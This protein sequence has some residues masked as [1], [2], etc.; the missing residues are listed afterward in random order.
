MNF[1]TRRRPRPVL[2]IIS[3]IDLLIVLL[4]FLVVSTSFREATS[5]LQLSL[6]QSTGSSGS[7]AENDRMV[8]MFTEDE[9]VRLGDAAVTLETL[10]T[11]IRELKQARP[12]LRFSIKIDKNV[13]FGASIRVLDALREAGLRPA[14][15]SILTAKQ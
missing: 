1:Y 13:K 14:D 4:I 8:V 11:A 6:P 12:D 5:N 9:Q 2:Q 7:A 15:Y 3:M 10:P